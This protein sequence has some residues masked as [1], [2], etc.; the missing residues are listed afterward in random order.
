MRQRILNLM[1]RGAFGFGV[2]RSSTDAQGIRGLGPAETAAL[3]LYGA[4]PE[5]PAP[6][7]SAV[8]LPS[9]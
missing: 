5:A 7:S 3:R 9:C 6:V 2:P 4:C 1:C 8:Q